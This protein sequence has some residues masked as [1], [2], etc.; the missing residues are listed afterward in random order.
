M[1]FESKKINK[2]TSN[3]FNYIK[4]H[5]CK[6]LICK[7]VFHLTLLL[8]DDRKLDLESPSLELLM[9]INSYLVVFRLATT[10]IKWLFLIPNRKKK[11]CP[12]PFFGLSPPTPLTTNC[13]KFINDIGNSTYNYIIMLSMREIGN[14]SG[15]RHIQPDRAWTRTDKG[16]LIKLFHVLS[17]Y[18]C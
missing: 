16:A 4:K 1:F 9:V 6:N 17:R 14:F 11:G 12:I 7:S 3:S 8:V 15:T 10:R 13:T 2:S 18:I 5:N